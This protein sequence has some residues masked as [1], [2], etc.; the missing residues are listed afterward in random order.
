MSPSL[1]VLLLSLL[2]GLQPAA[3]D[4]YLPSLPTIVLELDGTLSQAQLTLSAMLLMFGVSQLVWGPLSDRFGRRRILL[5]GVGCYV[6]AALGATLA[7][8]MEMLVLWR[9]LQGVGIGASVVCGRAIVRDLYTGEQGAR[10]MSKG[11]SGLGGIACVSAP[12]GGLLGVTLGWRASLA[13]LVLLGLVALVV[14]ALRFQETLK[15]PDPHALRPGQMARNWLHILGSRTFWTFSLLATGS[16]CVLFTFLAA[17]SFVMIDVFELPRGVFGLL[18]ATMSGTYILGTF[19][20][21]RLLRRFSLQRTIAIGGAL[22]LAGGSAM[23]LLSLAGILGPWAIMLP[24]YPI[25]LG[26]GI[27]QPCGQTGAVSPFPRSAGAAAALSG[28]VMTGAA[29]LTGLWLGPRMGETVYPLTL[30]I[31]FWTI[32]IALVAWIPVQRL[33]RAESH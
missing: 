25:M 7:H 14:V 29:F 11:M 9:T 33:S 18:L 21:R 12:L 32:A 19:L 1:V 15:H 30:G 13:A 23:G 16:Y 26:H 3:T 4:L 28:C 6:V 2:L 10:V 22:S 17:A 8:T 20:C 27:H 5:V 31:W 24:L